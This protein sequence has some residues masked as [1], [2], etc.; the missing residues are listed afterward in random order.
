MDFVEYL[1]S[2]ML[3]LKRKD[4]VHPHKGKLCIAIPLDLDRKKMLAAVEAVFKIANVRGAHYDQDAKYQ[5][6]YTDPRTLR[7]LIPAYCTWALKLCVE[8]SQVT[9]PIHKWKSYEMGKQLKA[10]PEHVTTIYD[11][12]KTAKA[13]RS[14][15]RTDQSRNNA[16]ALSLIANVEIGKFPCKANVAAKPRW[17]QAQQTELDQQPIL[18]LYYDCSNCL[19]KT[20]IRC[21]NLETA[22]F[23]ACMRPFFPDSL[24]VIPLRLPNANH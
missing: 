23:D 14:S 10:T 19:I 21:Q 12:P 2:G 17:T 7:K 13:K 6:I 22:Y 8:Q 9:N 15:M 4:L 1:V 3:V 18:R 5:L 11:S 20:G 16:S 24:D